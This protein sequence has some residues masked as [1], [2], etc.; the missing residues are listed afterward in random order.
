MK[1]RNK[2]ANPVGPNQHNRQGKEEEVFEEL[3]EKI[4]PS[5]RLPVPPGKK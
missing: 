4:R 3:S 5:D 2:L 1:G